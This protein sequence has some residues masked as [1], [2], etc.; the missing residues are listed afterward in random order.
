MTRKACQQK[1]PLI[2][3][4][5]A[6]LVCGSG[7]QPRSFKFATGSRSHTGFYGNFDF[8]DKHPKINQIT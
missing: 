2:W 1:I 8:S 3:K 5:Q 7:F 4:E 6:A